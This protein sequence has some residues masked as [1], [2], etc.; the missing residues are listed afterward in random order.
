[1]DRS[2][3]QSGPAGASAGASIPRGPPR[4]RG[5][6]IGRFT[7]LEELGR[8]GM[9]VVYAAYDP[10]LD[11]KVAVKLVRPERRVLL[12][13]TEPVARLVREGQTMARVSHPNV[14]TVYDV[15]VFEDEVF[16]A[17]EFV[18]GPTL[19]EWRG[20]SWREVVEVYVA[21]GRGLAA[22]HAAGLV[23]RDFKP[24]NVILAHGTVPKVTDFGLAKAMVDDDTV[25]VADSP[26]ST[27]T[28]T[29]TGTVIGTPRYMAPEQGRG[30]AT[31]ASDQYSFCKALD[32]ALEGSRPP[33][34]LRRVLGRG[35]VAEPAGR[36]PSMSVLLA[37]L[38]RDAGGRRH[39]A[40]FGA[41]A[42]LALLGGA[43]VLAGRSDPPCR[44][45]SAR[46]AGVWD[47]RVR[48]AVRAAFRASGAG[49]ADEAF[50]SVAQR[51]DAWTAEVSA[52]ATE[53]CE[54]TQ[55]RHEQSADLLDL[56]MACIGDR[57][58]EARALTGLLAHAD[59]ATVAEAPQGVFRLGSL[60]DCADSQALL[61]PERPPADKRAQVMD[62]RARLAAGTA[63]E[64]V[65]HFA[66]ARTVGEQAAD[67][68][69]ALGFRPVLAEALIVAGHSAAQAGDAEIGQKHLREAAWMAEA[70]RHDHA[71]ARAWTLLVFADVEAKL[72]D[73]ADDAAEHA[74]AAIAR[75]GGDDEL[76]M[77]LLSNRGKA[78]YYRG[79]YAAART[80]HER[81]LALAEAHTSAE[82]PQV[83]RVLTD[84]A[85]ALDAVNEPERAEKAYRRAAAIY[86][87][88]L[89]PNH[90]A[91][92]RTVANLA[93]HLRLRGD[94][95]GTIEMSR[96]AIGIYERS[97]GLEHP[98]LGHAELNLGG[99][100]LA[101][102]HTADARVAFEKA[103]AIYEKKMGADSSDAAKA[104]SSLGMTLQLEGNVAAALPLLE[105]A[106]AI[107]V[108][109]EGARHPETATAK[110]AHA[111]ALLWHG[112]FGPAAVELEDA[113]AGLTD[114]HGKAHPY[115][116]SAMTDLARA[117]LGTGRA[118]A[119]LA[120]LE[121]ALEVQ[122]AVK[123]PD[124]LAVTRFC[125][126]RAMWDTGGDRVKAREL[127]RQ[128]TTYP[129]SLSAPD[130]DA[131]AWL[132]SHGHD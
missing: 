50:A 49:V 119:A 59:A 102:G 41:I 36:Y 18:D 66:E 123:D 47:P 75:L 113:L 46:F 82:S 74:A 7:V 51:L 85:S 33:D 11:R 17:M 27:A 78:S 67:E 56:R 43:F 131:T 3:T 32:E 70:S 12:H 87:K 111:D 99:A 19:A 8:G 100:L 65:G 24:S 5:T 54:A 39:V 72:L 40:I 122:E 52:A 129:S 1:M 60:V 84:L 55:V 95:D 90:P 68:A 38:T 15:G 130:L 44:P 128:A 115:T 92:G 34:R 127:A 105:R 108:A 124:W 125:T 98:Y 94:L 89:G 9:G 132:A 86:E 103:L 62:I 114:A 10:E 23:H 37:A 80:F 20:Q 117:Y 88:T 96:R 21:A 31:A 6:V 57:V 91:V 81:A 120:L 83:A 16:L 118:K 107:H 121:Q 106:V 109:K 53:A 93:T 26:A 76:E 71:A 45:S 73:R 4:A 61:A 126:A 2:A 63:A 13:E 28:I 35:L 101:G 64:T 25:P 30:E 69:R 58:D 112:D 29:E 14:V 116:A 48:D 104:L 77:A 22:A 79:A 110:L 42:A 97:L